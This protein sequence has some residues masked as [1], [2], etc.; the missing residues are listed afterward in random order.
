MVRLR[1]HDLRLISFFLIVVVIRLEWLLVCPLS[2]TKQ[3]VSIG[4]SRKWD[5]LVPL[6]H[7]GQIEIVLNGV[8]VVFLDFRNLCCEKPVTLTLKKIMINKMTVNLITVF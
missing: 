7:P 3:N 8:N 4:K 2:D 6:D 5:E 1:R